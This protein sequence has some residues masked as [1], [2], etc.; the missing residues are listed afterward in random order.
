LQAQGAQEVGADDDRFP[1]SVEVVEW[2]QGADARLER[3]AVLFFDAAQIVIIEEMARAA[4]GGK[5]D[6]VPVP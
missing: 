1:D 4:R 3:L 5:H 2:E 6:D